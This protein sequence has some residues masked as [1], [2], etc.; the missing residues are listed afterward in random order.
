MREIKFRAWCP[1]QK[2]MFVP[3]IHEGVIITLDGKVGVYEDHEKLSYDFVEY[4]WIVMQYTGLKD[5]NG[6]EIYEGDIVEWSATGNPICPE[7]WVV[8]WNDRDGSWRIPYRDETDMV[9][10]VIGNI[11]EDPQM[12]TNK[13]QTSYGE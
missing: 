12:A 9:W 7:K 4:K 13:C 8:E 11:Y 2:E 5:R 6:K 3:N 10:R 1:E